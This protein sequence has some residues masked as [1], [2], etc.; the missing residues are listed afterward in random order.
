MAL[1]GVSVVESLNRLVVLLQVHVTQAHVVPD[2]PVV[3]SDTL[4]FLIHFQGGFVLAEKVPEHNRRGWT[5]R[6]HTPS[7][8]AKH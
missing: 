4:R 6:D 5:H 1:H 8:A 2:F 3:D 7:F